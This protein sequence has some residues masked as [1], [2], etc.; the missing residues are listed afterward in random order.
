MSDIHLI[1]CDGDRQIDTWG[2]EPTWDALDVVE[3]LNSLGADIYELI[4]DS[5][6]GVPI[7]NDKEGE[8]E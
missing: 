6:D 8:E 2:I 3:F 5:K 4:L 7:H 1:L